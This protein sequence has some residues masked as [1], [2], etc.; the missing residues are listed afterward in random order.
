MGRRTWCWC[1]VSMLA[2]CAPGNPGLV[3][4]GAL[5][6]SDDCS[7]ETSNL[8]VHTGVLDV[9]PGRVSYT[10]TAVVFNQLI[11]LAS[12]TGGMGRPP[13][14]D[15]NVITIQQAEVELRDVQENAL[16]LA[17]APNPYTVPAHG[18]IPSSDGTEAGSGIA[19]AEIIPPII[20]EGLRG[21]AGSQI[22]AV[23]RF[24]FVTAGG[25]EDVTAEFAWPIELCFGC[26]FACQPTDEGAL[27]QP[28]C[29][30][31]QD[32]LT[33]SPGAC[34]EPPVFTSCLAEM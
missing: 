33:I 29:T 15:P 19:I 10:L 8:T 27:C 7:Y 5:A 24:R 28:S 13:M 3:I 1:L 12:P 21:A 6:P 26:L 25:V 2:G 17:G 18:F 16:A 4:G 9:A 34:A 14:A 30:P 11:N 20:G 31:G 23:V 22:V 32:R